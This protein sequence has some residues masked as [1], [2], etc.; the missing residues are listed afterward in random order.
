MCARALCGRDITFAHTY[1]GFMVSTSQ[2]PFIAQTFLQELGQNKP[3]GARSSW[4]P[5]MH[6]FSSRHL[7]GADEK[8]ARAR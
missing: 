7:A 8:P 6:M 4:E 5:E 1:L 2:Y 3:K